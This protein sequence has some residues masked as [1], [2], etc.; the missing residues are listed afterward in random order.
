LPPS[1][2]V[3]CGPSLLPQCCPRRPRHRILPLLI[4]RGPSATRPPPSSHPAARPRA[5]P[6]APAPSGAP[7]PLSGA[8]EAAP[9]CSRGGECRTLP[10]LPP[11]HQC[12]LTLLCCPPGLS[13]CGAPPQPPASAAPLRPR[14][15]THVAALA[16]APCAASRLPMAGRHV[17]GRAGA[18]GPRAPR[19]RPADVRSRGA[20]QPRIL[21][22]HRGHFLSPTCK[23]HCLSFV[24]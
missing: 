21:Q 11:M 10:L 9:L 6:R 1:P 22:A 12:L 23:T 5:S 7:C 19:R 18:P 17:R 13:P 3:S 14:R 16:L 2:S 24:R 20:R 4:S 15:P 8:F